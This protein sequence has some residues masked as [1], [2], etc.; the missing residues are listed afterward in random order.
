MRLAGEYIIHKGADRIVIPNQVTIA[1]AQAM[2]RSA[3]QGLSTPWALGL[4]AHN[5]A[6]AISL[7]NINE[8]P[9]GVNGYAR[10]ALASNATNWPTTGLIN[11]ESY[12]E[13]RPVTFGISAQLSVQVNRLFITD[14]EYVLSVS[15]AIDGG[16]QYMD[17][18]Y[19][20]QY[21]LYL[22]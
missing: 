9:V 4:C 11:G 22:R 3:F 5:Q 7:L 8:P 18:P 16:L 1:G 14:G 2:L 6:D 13:S 10:Q 21:R 20:T 19:T 15:S 12:I 17:S